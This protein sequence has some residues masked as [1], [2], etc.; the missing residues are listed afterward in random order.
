[1][2]DVGD[3][4]PIER[5]FRPRPRRPDGAE[6]AVPEQPG[7]GVTVD[8]V[9]APR[10]AVGAGRGP[11]RPRP[12]LS[13]R[14]AVGARRQRRFLMATGAMSALVLLTSGGAWAFNNYAT[15][16]VEPL[17]VEGLGDDDGGPKGA[18]TILVAGVDRREG[19]TREQQKAARLGREAGERSD[20]MMLVHVSRDHDRIAVVSLPRDSLVTIPAHRSN[21]SEGPKGTPVPA[22]QGKLTW[23]YQFGGPNLTVATVKRA[24]GVSIDHYVEVNFYGFVN[25][26]DA[27]GGVDVCVEQPVNDRKSGLR[28]PAG[29]THVNGLQAL[30]FSRA[31]YT[32]TGGS[33][34]GRIDRQQQLMAS[35]MK[36]AIS[37]R[38]LSDPVKAKR[39]LDATL[40]SLR[41]DE[42]LADDLDELAAQMSDLS[43][44]DITFAKIPLRSEN[45]MTPINGSAPQSTVLWD[46]RGAR[47]LFGRIRRDEPL[48][49]PRPRPT[50]AAPTRDPNAP[51]VQPGDIT[52]TVRNGVGT[53]GLAARAAGDLREVG[54]RTVVPPGVARTGLKITQIRYGPAHA[55][56]A[57]TLAAAIPGAKVREDASVGDGIQVIV[58]ADWN[59]AEEVSVQGLPG[60]VPS[61]PSGPQTSTA[62]QKLCK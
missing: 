33:D 58:G 17:L 54:F 1:M 14:A 29:T 52:V 2:P 36:Q 11:R 60:A 30:A 59:G 62:S 10:V 4:D 34:L 47:E 12:Q 55:D 9:P 13:P 8:G 5:Y 43:T 26:V 32:L 7:E 46:D 21:G 19:L 6:D 15:S 49:K 27:L 48:A 53:R 22:R 42:E 23:A 18:M 38:T 50:T 35:L 44:D 16:L 37:T 24:T 39:V 45:H 28:L 61:Q 41:V 57:R 3:S 56:A 51:T 20:T 40:K 25:I 31:R